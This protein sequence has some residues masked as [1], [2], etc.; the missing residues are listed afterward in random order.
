MQK[1]IILVTPPFVQLSS[2][3]PASAFLKG[4][5]KQ[6]NFI[7]QQYDFSISTALTLFSRN[8]LCKLFD[9]IERQ[10]AN[11]ALTN[12]ELLAAFI[13]K[14]EQYISTI[15]PVILFLQGKYPQLAQ[16]ILS[17]TYLPEGPRFD[18]LK[19]SKHKNGSTETAI[20]FASLYIDDLTDLYSHTVLPHFG[21]S[22]Y[23]ASIAQSNDLTFDDI[24]AF[25]KNDDLLTDWLADSIKKLNLEDCLFVGI[26]I[27]FPG[28]FCMAVKIAQILKNNKSDIK[29]VLGGGFINTGFRNIKEKKLFDYADFIVLDDGELPLIKLA[30]YLNGKCEKSSLVRTFFCD[31]EKICYSGNEAQNYKKQFIPDYDDLPLDSYFTLR[32]STNSMHSLWSQRIYLKLR[33]AHGCYHH[34]CTFCDTSLDYIATYKAEDGAFLAD[35]AEKLIAQTGIRSFHFIDE[36][37]PPAVIKTF[38]IEIL[39][40]G[41]D[42]IWWGNIRFDSAFDSDLPYLMSRAG[43][44]AVTGG[45]ESGCN[46]ILS[47]MNKK[48]TV[49]TIIRVSKKFA[50]SNILVH[51]YLIYGFPGEK[52]EEIAETLEVVRQMFLEKILHSVFFHKFTLTVHS[53]IFLNPHNFSITEINRNQK[54]L[55]DYDISCKESIPSTKLNKIG[56]ILNTA[57]YNFNLRNCLEI[58]AAQWMKTPCKIKP[59]FVKSVLD[60]IEKIDLGK[61]CYWLGT[62]PVFSDGIL[63]FAGK[64]G[65]ISYELPKTLANWVCR[66]L[67]ESSPKTERKSS[68]GK[69]S[70]QPLKYWLNSLPDTVFEN[71]ECFFDNELWNDLRKA[72]LIL[73]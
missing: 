36:A 25:L 17:R 7:V 1:K 40:R 62:E 65:D 60:N 11:G 6:E 43:C 9:E 59:H 10:S 16:K 20:H 48:T 49:E 24:E 63:Y 44:I 27:P 32:E 47:L 13:T 14:K 46:R 34:K 12:S 28:N 52:P 64:Y 2:P 71:K 33:M 54:K 73:L 69:K 26:S 31:G 39:K 15:E 50:Q 66:L 38:C 29:V 5:L 22:S 45:M 23:A 70:Y 67:K 68:N 53:E 18:E 72:G 41:L 56:E 51:G 35:A 37:M 4:A 3:Y 8:G 61:K 57:V 55:T 19:N 30:E 21:L 58:P 42:I